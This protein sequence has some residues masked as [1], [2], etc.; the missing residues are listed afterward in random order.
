VSQ[1]DMTANQAVLFILSEDAIL[2]VRRFGAVLQTYRVKLSPSTVSGLEWLSTLQDLSKQGRDAHTGSLRLKVVIAE[3]R[4]AISS[5][6]WPSGKNSIESVHAA[7]RDGLRLQGWTVDDKDVV[8][9]RMALPGVPRLVV[10]YSSVLLAALK[11]WSSE[12]GWTVH[13]VEPLGEALAC[14]KHVSGTGPHLIAVSDGA[15]ALLYL[16][17]DRLI[18]V[19]VRPIPASGTAQALPVQLDGWLAR[20]RLRCSEWAHAS[21]K[22][23]VSFG[24]L[25]PSASFNGW[26]VLLDA[27]DKVHA[28]S[29]QPSGELDG[30]VSARSGWRLFSV[31]M[32]ALFISLVTA[33]MV[34]LNSLASLALVTDRKV[35]QSPEQDFVRTP[36]LGESGST[37]QQVLAV[38]QAVMTL[39]TPVAKLLA[40]VQP[41]KDIDVS[42]LSL[43]L[44]SANGRSALKLNVEARHPAD[45]F[46]YVEYLA[47][48]HPI[49]EAHMTDH[50]FGPANQSVGDRST[51]WRFTVEAK[52]LP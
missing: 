10:A 43:S 44:S 36:P 34:S 27:Q 40:A 52:W 4:L 38:N 22:T 29:N 39:N 46:R 30:W 6:P 8:V 20:R 16:V 5:L 2:Q 19:H 37:K 49:H 48:R 50:D 32:V 45:M 18:D 35:A 47:D 41:P 42:L 21:A 23:L 17:D 3:T 7:W 14:I 24:V 15:F 28:G 51:V 33:A 13:S 9:A 11:E 1:A 26:D 12:V 31:A 25:D